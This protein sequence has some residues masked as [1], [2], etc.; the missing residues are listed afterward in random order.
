MRSSRTSSTPEPRPTRRVLAGLLCL[1]LLS[2]LLSLCLGSTALSPALVPQALLGQLKGTLEGDIVQFVRLP[3]T[4]GC[5]LAGMALAVS[6]AM[7][8]SVLQN[9]L[10]APNIIG[11]NSGAGASGGAVERP[12]L[13]SRWPSPPWPPSWGPFWGC[14]WCWS[15]PSAPG[16]SRITLVLAGVAVSNIFSAGIDAPGHLLPRCGAQLH[17]LPHR[18]AGQPVDGEAAPRLLGDPRRPAAPVLPV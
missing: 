17:R 8:Q 6:G 2:A 10:A 1:T 13:P 11:V 5:L 3:R 16:P 9:P 12:G 14:C 15:S 7:I 18:R 4:C